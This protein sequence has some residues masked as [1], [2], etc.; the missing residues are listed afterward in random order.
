[1]L[2]LIYYIVIFGVL[3]K[4]PHIQVHLTPWII[5]LQLSQPINL[6]NQSHPIPMNLSCL[7]IHMKH[8]PLPEPTLTNSNTSNSSTPSI[9]QVRKSIRERQPPTWH[10]E[11]IMP[12][13]VNRSSS[14]STSRTSTRYPL[15]NCLSYSCVSSTHF[16]FLANIKAH[17]EPH[18]YDQAVQDPHW[19][20]A[21]DA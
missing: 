8:L 18:C 12:K 16:A 7:S 6:N 13:K 1:M 4:F 20:A 15:S 14:Q 17:T 9:P 10:R 5:G 19:Q 21:M 2:L 11:F 3:I